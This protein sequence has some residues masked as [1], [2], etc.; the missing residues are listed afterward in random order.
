MVSWFGWSRINFSPTENFV[1]CCYLP[2]FAF[3]PFYSRLLICLTPPHTLLTTEITLNW[4]IFSRLLHLKSYTQS[5]QKGT[6]SP[7][8]L[9]KNVH[10]QLYACVWCVQKETANIQRID[11]EAVWCRIPIRYKQKRKKTR[12]WFR[13]SGRSIPSSIVKLALHS[14]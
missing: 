7:R 14:N 12:K 13:I 4:F 6:P 2:S 11:S 8:A 3:L 9:I 10:C 5:T 1:W